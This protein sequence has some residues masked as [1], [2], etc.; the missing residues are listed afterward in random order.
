MDFYQTA[1]QRSSTFPRCRLHGIR[2]VD[3]LPPAC[4]HREEFF[5]DALRDL[6]D[7][8]WARLL[9][10]ESSG[11]DL[12]ERMRICESCRLP[13]HVLD[14]LRAG[15]AQSPASTPPPV[16]RSPGSRSIALRVI[17]K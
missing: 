9:G 11:L 17:R 6:Q 13:R 8:G 16:R 3:S 15:R 10:D 1:R 14:R 12:L 2:L 4:P 5:L 7:E